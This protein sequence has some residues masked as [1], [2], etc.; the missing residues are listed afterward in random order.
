MF[1]AELIDAVA[2]VFGLRSPQLVPKLLQAVKANATL[3]SGH[4]GQRHQ[5]VNKRDDS[6]LLA[7]END[8]GFR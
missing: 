8:L 7:E 5:P 1:G 4:R 3:R 2:Q 6:I